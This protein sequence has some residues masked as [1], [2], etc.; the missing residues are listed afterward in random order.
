[1]RSIYSSVW[2]LTG[3]GFIKEAPAQIVR[4]PVQKNQLVSTLVLTAIT[5]GKYLVKDFVGPIEKPSQPRSHDG[6]LENKI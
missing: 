1:M 5:V 3:I 2:T 6:F 4:K